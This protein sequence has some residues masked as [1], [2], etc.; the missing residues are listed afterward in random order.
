MW[1]LPKIPNQTEGGTMNAKHSMEEN[2]IGT[3]FIFFELINL[4]RKNTGILTNNFEEI[5]D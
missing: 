2:L 1:N 4:K 3:I 5:S